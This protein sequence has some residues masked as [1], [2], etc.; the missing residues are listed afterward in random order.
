MIRPAAA[1]AEILAA[2]ARCLLD[3][4]VEGRLQAFGP[5]ADVARIPARAY[6]KEQRAQLLTDVLGHVAGGSLFGA[7]RVA[8]VLDGI[9]LLKEKA[10]QAWLER[11]PAGVHLIL[12]C[13]AARPAEA[14]APRGVRIEST[15]EAGP[16]GVQPM[17]DWMRDRSGGRLTAT[18]QNRLLERVGRDLDG[19]AAEVDKLALLQPE[20][21]IHESHVDA[22]VGRTSGQD[23]D[24]FWDALKRGQRTVALQQFERMGS[25][26]LSLFGGSR[27]YGEVATASA[28]LPMLFQRIRR[29]GLLGGASG[30]L[31]DEVA[32]VSRISPGYASFLQRDARDIGEARLARWLGVVLEAETVWKRTAHLSTGELLLALIVELSRR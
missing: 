28:L 1:P 21:E 10:L 3:P 26:G 24:R 6:A 19:L 23:F 11:P 14:A 7:V 27:I 15:Y 22:L 31:R 17:R 13:V 25:E 12:A 32:R 18:A 5:A 16:S 20:G 9:A 2:P 30:R 4:M 8:V 29:V